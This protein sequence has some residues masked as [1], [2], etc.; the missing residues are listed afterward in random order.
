MAETQLHERSIFE[1]AR[2]LESR[3]A[4]R[5]YLQQACGANAALEARIAALLRAY[6]E[7]SSFLESPPPGLDTSALTYLTRISRSLTA[8]ILPGAPWLKTN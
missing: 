4:R 7:G 3:D 5:S 8:Y 1:I 6:D 2:K